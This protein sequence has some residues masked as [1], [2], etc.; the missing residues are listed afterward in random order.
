M[1]GS[2]NSAV[3]RIMSIHKTGL[4]RGVSAGALL[5]AFSCFPAAGQTPAAQ[6]GAEQK[7]RVPARVTDTMD[8]TNRT[9][10]R[11]NVHPKARA[12][13]DRGAVA[14]AQPGT[15]MLLGLQLSPEREPALPQ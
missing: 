8:D 6:S 7:S 11:G 3:G 5:L 15:R 4:T 9:V 1:M 13:F 12:E 10:L 2:K 14:G